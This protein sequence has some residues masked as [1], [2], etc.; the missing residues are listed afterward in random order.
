MNEF[1]AKV[2]QTAIDLLKQK[3]ALLAEERKNII[4]SILEEEKNS[5]G[6]KYET[7]RETMTQDLN[8]IEKQ[9]K[10]SKLDLEELYRLNTIKDTPPTVQEGALVKL[11][12]E[13]FLLAVS[14]GQIKVND[15]KVFLLSKNSPLGELLIGKKKKEQ[16][17]FRG[18]MQVVEELA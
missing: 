1:K 10:Q 18:K 12:A 13:W 3:E 14:I 8:S 17:N 6:D 15:S 16:I 5:A 4:E 2:Y 7:S 9:I 11:G